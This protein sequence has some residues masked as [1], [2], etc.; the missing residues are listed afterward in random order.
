MST[1]LDTIPKTQ[2]LLRNQELFSAEVDED[3][4]MMDEAQGVYFGLNSIAKSVW[5]LLATPKTI[6]ELIKNLTDH[7]EID[8]VQCQADLTPF[9]LSCVDNNLIHFV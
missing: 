7:Y 5:Q 9:L 6:P 1:T 3:L 8:A 4:V 2:A